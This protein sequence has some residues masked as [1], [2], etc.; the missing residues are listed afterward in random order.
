MNV[1]AFDTC[2]GAV[3]AAVRWRGRGGDGAARGLRAALRRPCRAAVSDDRRGH[4]RRRP[5][6]RR[7]RPHRRDARAR[8]LHRRARRHR[9][10][11][12]PGAGARQAGRGHHQPRR[13]GASRRGAAGRAA[14]ERASSWSPSMPGAARSTSR[15]SPRAEGRPARPSCSRRRRP[16]SGSAG[17][18]PSSSARGQ[19][20][21]AAAVRTAG[22]RGARPRLPDLQPH[23]RTLADMAAGP[24]ADRPVKPLYLRAAGRQ[25]AGR[26]AARPEPAMTRADAAGR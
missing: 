23:A 21:V 6:V 13:H 3:S 9:R 24:R 14:R 25:A 12:R 4:G 16:R 18:A 22:R 2:F 17:T 1:L 26:A 7:H 15:A 5:A 19:R 20:R 10:G 11:A 8:H